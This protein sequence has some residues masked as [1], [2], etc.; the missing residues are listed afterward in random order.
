MLTTKK[1]YQSLLNQPSSVIEAHLRIG[2]FRAGSK[3]H[4]LETYLTGI[5]KA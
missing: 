3:T 4:G 1:K 2:R 5:F